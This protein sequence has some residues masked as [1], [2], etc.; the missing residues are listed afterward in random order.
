MFG[1]DARTSAPASREQLKLMLRTL[2]ADRFKLPLHSATKQMPVY[3]LTSAKNGPKLQRADERGFSVGRGFVR[4]TMDI[5]T[6]TR[7]LTSILGRTVVDATGLEGVYKVA[8]MWSPDD[9][10]AAATDNPGPSIF[11]AIQ[12]QL[13]LRLE[14]PKGPVQ[15]LVIDKAGKPSEN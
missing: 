14:A 2:L 8:L 1:I 15:V 6:L 7:E 10:T 5:S 3:A 9:Q 4:G 12:E 11:T 13:G